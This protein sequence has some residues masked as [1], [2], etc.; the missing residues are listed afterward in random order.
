MTDKEIYDIWAPKGKKWTDWVRPVPFLGMH[1]HS[2]KYAYSQS[3]IPVTSF[4]GM[5]ISDIAVIVDLPGADSVRVAISLAKEGFRP[6]PIFNGTLEPQGARATVDN[7]TVGDAL[8]ALAKQL[9]QIPIKEDA[10][11]AFLADENRLLRYKMEEG[12][13]D[14]SWDVYPQDLPSA[15]YLI[16]NGINKV[17]ILGNGVSKDIKKIVYGYQKKG[18]VIFWTDGYD[19]P[20]RIKVRKPIFKR[21]SD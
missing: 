21:K 16:E 11:P 17:V 3:L 5:D 18:L 7:H 15:Q 9:M 14:N 8:Y 4:A 1:E 10:P 12:L 13:F 6:I 19:V 20:K 2:K